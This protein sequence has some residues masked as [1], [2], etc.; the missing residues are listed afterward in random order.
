MKSRTF[1]TLLLVVLYALLIT[2]VI[3]F[4]Q[5]PPKGLELPFHPEPFK[6]S[7]EWKGKAVLVELFTGSECPPC[8]ASDLA[9]DALLEAYDSKYLAILE[10]HLPIPGPDPMM[11]P[12]TSQRQKFYGVTSTPSTFFE[13][14]NKHMGGGGISAAKRK[15]DQYITSIDPMITRTPQA[16]LQL[17]AVLDGD[18]VKIAWSSDDNLEAANYNFALVQEEEKYEGRNKILIHK[19]VVRDFKSLDSRTDAKS[20]LTFNIPEAEDA[21]KKHLQDFEQKRKFKFKKLHNEIDHSQ[22]KIVFF[23]QDKDFQIV[24]NAIVSDVV[25]K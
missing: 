24:Y 5:N 18:I 4:S 19:M 14:L 1:R 17:S 11:N 10:Y 9:F 23:V 6:L 7:G 3:S 20:E 15:Y 16:K 13:G 8:V 2:P 21:A 12:A 25:A 22:L